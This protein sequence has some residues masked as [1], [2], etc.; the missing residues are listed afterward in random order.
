MRV[1][2]Q[3]THSSTGVVSPNWDLAE[4]PVGTGP[5]QFVVYEPKERIVGERFDDYGA[6]RHRWTGSRS[7]S[8]P[9]PAA[10]VWR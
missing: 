5:F 7:G 9:S 3:L 10:V 6:S 4:R 1:P 8:T 2:Q